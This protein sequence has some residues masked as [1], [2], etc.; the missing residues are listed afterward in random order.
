MAKQN[1]ITQ[2]P[3]RFKDQDLAVAARRRVRYAGADDAAYTHAIVEF[4]N[5]PASSAAGVQALFE[6]Y[7]MRVDSMLDGDEMSPETMRSLARNILAGL[8]HLSR[9]AG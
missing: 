2:T 3:L 4:E 1:G 8:K 7:S 9:R 6:L 5:A